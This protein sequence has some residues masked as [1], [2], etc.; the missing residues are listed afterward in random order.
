M[1]LIVGFLV[2]FSSIFANDLE[3]KGD[4]GFEY[5]KQNFSNSFVKD[6]ESKSINTQLEFTYYYE[7]IKAFTKIEALK[8]KDNHDRQYLKLNEAYIKYE[9]DDYE[10]LT[11]KDIRFWGSLELYNLTD[12]YNKK[13]LL[14]DPYDKDKKLGTKNMTFNKYFENEDELSI[15][16]ANESY[17]KYIKYSGSRD[18]VDFSFILQNDDKFLTYNT[19][20]I[21]DTIY[22]LEYLYSFKDNNHYEFGSGIEHTLYGLIDKKDL[23]VIV[24]YYKSDNISLQNQDDVFVGVRITFNDIHSSDIVAGTIKDLDTKTYGYSFEYNTRFFDTF[25]TKLIYFKND[26]FDIAGL[27]VGYYF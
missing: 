5:K 2:I 6:I 8:D 23:G 18:E 19:L 21:D 13:N 11:G 25:K 4:I 24:E 26:S 16:I 1:K 20:V 12:I 3:I 9:A 17:D 22:K 14:N 27:S 7:D 10:I 15:S